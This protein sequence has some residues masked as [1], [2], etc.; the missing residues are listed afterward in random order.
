MRDS[1][2]ITAKRMATTMTAVNS[3]Y[4]KTIIAVPPTYDNKPLAPALG[5]TLAVI[6]VQAPDGNDT[7]S[8][9]RLLG[10]AGGNP[11]D[12]QFH[13]HQRSVLLGAVDVGVLVREELAFNSPPA[14]VV[15]SNTM[16]VDHLEMILKPLAK[17]MVVGKGETSG[18][19]SPPS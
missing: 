3:P 16:D 5:S 19:L 6:R 4:V 14:P 2:N 12:G 10:A 18:Y 13:V 9:G 1:A 11:L 17:I 7:A 15:E 8:A